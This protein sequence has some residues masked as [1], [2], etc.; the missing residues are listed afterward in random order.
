VV[1]HAVRTVGELDP[2][3]VLSPER[4]DPRRLAGGTAGVPLTQVCSIVRAAVRAG[5]ADAQPGASFFV[6]DTSAAREGFL[7]VGREA[8][9][10]ARIGSLKR[11]VR[12]GDVLVSRLRPYLRQVAYVD[13][14]AI[15]WSGYAMA[16]STEF[17]VLRS[18]DEFSIAFL[19]PFLLSA[20]VQAVLA[21]AQEG[22]H[23]PRVSETTIASLRLPAGL[24]AER[25]RLS[26]AVE[27]AAGD[28][29]TATGTVAALVAEFG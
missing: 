29:R 26:E 17:Y 21:A 5:G 2:G 19:V 6:I 3:Y 14:R 9:P 25:Q 16:C 11:L 27:R 15:D 28:Y 10:A 18:A 1:K 20:D 8:V 24:L 12:P 22:G 13:A 7:V 23:H 4:Y